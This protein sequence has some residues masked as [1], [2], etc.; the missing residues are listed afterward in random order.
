MGW[1][2]AAK[3]QE[4]YNA[5]EAARRMQAMQQLGIGQSEALM[6]SLD[7]E[8]MNQQIGDSIKRF[9]SMKGGSSKRDREKNAFGAQIARQQDVYKQAKEMALPTSA[10]AQQQAGS[11]YDFSQQRGL[12]G[13]SDAMRQSQQGIAQSVARRGLQGS[14]TGLLASNA[15]RQPY[16]QQQ[17]ISAAAAPLERYNAVDQARQQNLAERNNRMTTA[18]GGA[19]N[20]GNM[21]QMGQLKMSTG[22]WGSKLV[23]PI[24][25]AGIT[26]LTGG[27]GAPIG[28]ALGGLGGAMGSG[29]VNGIGGLFGGGSSSGMGDMLKPKQQFQSNLGMGNYSF[30]S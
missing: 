4:G 8:A 3:T 2:T 20:A 23:K 11:M 6:G 1:F 13:L 22:G 5:D 26:A 10:Q 24:V 27:M 21:A 12:A 14:V 18:M 17:T 9:A 30:G 7:P 25:G 29:L 19:G 16:L 15:A 28:A